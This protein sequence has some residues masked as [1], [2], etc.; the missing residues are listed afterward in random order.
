RL[1]HL[2]HEMVYSHLQLLPTIWPGRA[3][4]L[5]ARQL[6]PSARMKLRLPVVAPPCQSD[7]HET[8]SATD[9]PSS[10]RDGRLYAT[11]PS[12]QAE[13]S[14]ALWSLRFPFPFHLLFQRL[15]LPQILR[16]GLQHL[17][18][19]PLGVKLLVALLRD[20]PCLF[21]ADRAGTFE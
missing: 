19:P 5:R 6:Q 18:V 14:Q 10:P 2:H 4:C 11:I 8:R 21:G 13:A 17:I 7:S 20:P 9:S 16:I 3:E 1:Q 15:Q 12:H